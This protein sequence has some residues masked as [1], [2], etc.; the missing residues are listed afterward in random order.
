MKK[1]AKVLAAIMLMTAVFVTGCKPEDDPNNGGGEI[2]TK[3][4]DGRIGEELD[5]SNLSVETMYGKVALTGNDFSI[6]V[7]DTEKLQFLAVTDADTNIY[8]LYRGWMLD[9]NSLVIDANSTALALVTMHPVLGPI[10]NADE[11]SQLK[12]IIESNSHYIDI[13]QSV[14]S[15]I[16][17]HRPVSDTTN[18]ELMNALYGFF[19]ELTELAGLDSLNGRSDVS[20]FLESYP[21]QVVT[22]DNTLTM[23]VTGLSPSYY[24]TVTTAQGHT[25]NN[26][27][28][29]RADYG[30]MDLFTHTVENVHWGVPTSYVFRNQGEYSFD[31]SKNNPEG[32]MDFYLH[33]ANNI[34][35]GVL[36]IDMDN[37]QLNQL[38]ETI[39]TVLQLHQGDLGGDGMRLVGWVYQGVVDYLSS[40]SNDGF[41]RNWRLAGAL[42]RRLTGVY[43]VIKGSCNGLLRV[44]YFFQAPDD[45]SFCLEYYPST[46]INP[47]SETT[48]TIVGGNNQT[49]L[50]NE[51]LLHPLEVY[52]QSQTDNGWNIHLDFTVRFEVVSGGGELSACDVKVDEN[53]KARTYW[54]LGEFDEQEVSAVVVEPETGEELSNK[55][56]FTA[57]LD[58]GVVT[59]LPVTDV[60][61][62]SAK[63]GGVISQESLTFV[64]RC[65]V[66]WNSTG[67]PT[68]DDNNVFTDPGTGTYH[69]NMIGLTSNTA[70]YVRAFVE[71]GLEYHY[72]N[73]VVFVTSGITAG[74]W[75]DL[76]LPSGLLWATCNVGATTPEGYGDYFAWGETQPKSVYSWDTYKYYRCDD[77]GCGYTK[78]CNN[79]SYGYNGY[80]DNLTTLLSGDD[81]A[82]V[83]WEGGARMPTYNEWIELYKHCSSTWMTMNGV[84]GRC[85]TEPNGNSL[86][87]PAAGYRG[88]DE[89]YT[90]GSYGFYWSSTLGTYYPYIAWYF[91]FNSGESYMDFFFNGGRT[92]GRS[93]R[94]VRSAK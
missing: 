31:F 9:E 77:Y 54:T 23:R 80:M 15:A 6:E 2:I 5:V 42:L 29:S 48:V 19:E 90:V 17:A 81:A 7:A 71:I 38:S 14:S 32:L 4:I 67:M 16:T 89:L 28:L 36:G 50:G 78:Y 20:D 83:N 65:G 94:A 64:T 75:V 40:P 26:R 86:F 25:E 84:N 82:T 21:M 52:V 24:G 72:G 59:T 69:C 56:Y 74:D 91:Y 43:D 57:S 55:V 68:I 27:V 85:F 47:C 34:A 93:V 18:V 45:I 87:L 60:T 37:D 58:E 63:G 49:G 62:T 13:R 66:C 92:P 44:A 61:Q 12:D 33:L 88:G 73:E 11:Y 1:L 10:V 70:Y 46:G 53:H 41:W 3:T 8:M 22:N 76:G 39:A 35:G 30:G 79:S 51:Q